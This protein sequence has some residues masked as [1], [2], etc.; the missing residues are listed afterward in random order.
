V[1]RLLASLALLIATP[2]LVF[3]GLHA[4][5]N[6][7]MRG[8]GGGAGLVIGGALALATISAG[9]IL[10]FASLA[11][12]FP[13]S[14]GARASASDA[15]G[16]PPTEP[17]PGRCIHCGYPMLGLDRRGRCPECGFSYDLDDRAQSLG[18]D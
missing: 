17:D 5:L 18:A 7:A 2:V 6:I 3:A 15:P 12:A 14:R 13:V 1:T 16:G 4:A 9:V 11:I 10:L 8:G